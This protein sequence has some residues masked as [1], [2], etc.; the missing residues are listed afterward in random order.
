MSVMT[1]NLCG[2]PEVYQSWGETALCRIH[3]EKLYKDAQVVKHQ[4]SNEIELECERCND[5]RQLSQKC[6]SDH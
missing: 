1:C 5:E 4:V 2:N 3:F 6:P